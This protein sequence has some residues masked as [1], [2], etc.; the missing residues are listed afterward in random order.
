MELIGWLGSLCL[1]I[2]ALPQAYN[3]M[4]LGR[5]DGIQTSF[6]LLW[7]TG[8]VL[9]LI[10]SG[11]KDVLPLLFNYG[12]NILFISIILYFKMYPRSPA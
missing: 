1:A 2:C 8:E 7:L 12:F 5:S 11:G 10:Y 3:A 4:R 9:A 6:L